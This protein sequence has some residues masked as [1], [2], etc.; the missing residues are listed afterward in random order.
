MKSLSN[1]VIKC[2]S[3][4]LIH[5]FLLFNTVML[6]VGYGYCSVQSSVENKATLSPALQIDKNVR[7]VFEKS[8]A[9]PQG[10]KIKAILLTGILSLLNIFFPGCASMELTPFPDNLTPNH[11]Y[12][13]KMGQFQQKQYYW[14]PFGDISV[15]KNKITLSSKGYGYGSVRISLSEIWKKQQDLKPGNSMVVLRIKN[16]TMSS[17]VLQLLSPSDNAASSTNALLVNLERVSS[18]TINM[19]LGANRFDL[20]DTE[21]V[22]HTGPGF[23]GTNSRNNYTN[24]L[25]ITSVS[26]VPITQKD[27]DRNKAIYVETDFASKDKHKIGE[28]HPYGWAKVNKNPD[29]SHTLTTTRERQDEGGWPHDRPS[30]SYKFYAKKGRK[31]RIR[32]SNNDLKKIKVNGKTH[33]LDPAG[34][35]YA[36]GNYNN[37]VE[38]VTHESVIIFSLGNKIGD[39]ISIKIEYVDNLSTL[40]QN[41]HKRHESQY[42]IMPSPTFSLNIA[43][44]LGS[45]I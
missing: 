9:K 31:V 13:M 7:A 20:E 2:V 6:P 34:V 23:W 35:I 1:Q 15:A 37:S 3:L 24:S 17:V 18:G 38:L 32:Y 43:T 21:L 44:I 36:E 10:G 27:V 14:D 11:V 28:V 39:S 16:N 42:P 5:A 30:A 8:T 45:S 12:I 33:E 25:E 19:P 29:G 41:S 4:I 26:I 40:E 22:L